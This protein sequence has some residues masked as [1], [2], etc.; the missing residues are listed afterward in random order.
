[1]VIILRLWK[2]IPVLLGEYVLTYLGV[3]CHDGAS[4]F[5]MVQPKKK[6]KKCVCV[7]RESKCGKI[8]TIGQSRFLNLF[9]MFKDFFHYHPPP[10][11]QFCPFGG[12]ISPTETE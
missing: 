3:K 6:N 2:K 9:V 5:Q 7:K 12:N 10:M 11:N 8:L 4:N 1:M